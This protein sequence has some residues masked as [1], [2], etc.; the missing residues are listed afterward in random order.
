MQTA[1]EALRLRT[2]PSSAPA[3]DSPSRSVS[4][5][6]CLTYS[7]GHS[8]AH[9]HP[10]IALRRCVAQKWGDCT[11]GVRAHRRAIAYLSDANRRVSVH[12]CANAYFADRISLIFKWDFPN[13]NHA[14][15]INLR[16]IRKA[17]QIRAPSTLRAGFL[18]FAALRWPSAPPRA[19][20]GGLPLGFLGRRRAAHV[21]RMRSGAPEGNTLRFV[22]WKTRLDSYALRGA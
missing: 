1:L 9:R 14:V 5:V 7:H 16:S 6:L 4:P 10:E 12:H 3:G 19:P 2:R 17:S 8:L 22:L 18:P 15:R 21:S 20:I 13:L 11:W